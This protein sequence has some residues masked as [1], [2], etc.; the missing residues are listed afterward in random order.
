MIRQPAVSGLFYS[1]SPDT[2]AGDVARYLDPSAVP[3]PAVALISPHAGLMYSGHVAGAVYARV[4]LPPT[5]ILLG[6]NHTGVGPPI[7]VYREGTWLIPGWSVDVDHELADTILSRY[8]HARADTSA[9]HSE[10]CLEVQ[11]PFL[12]RANPHI[13]IVPIVLGHCPEE[14]YQELGFCLAGILDERRRENSAATP[15]LVS[16]TDMSHYEP[17]A[18]TRLKD[19][20]AIDAI[21]NLDPAGLGEAVRTYQIT[22]CGYAPTVTVLHAVRSLGATAAA[23]IRYATSG[24]VSGERT[25]VVGYAGLV[26]R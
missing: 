13:R 12:C 8:P 15:L 5:V 7:S 10:H 9:H 16:S 18:T 20:H 19:G 11:L 25:R 6:P 17:D 3:E 26:I 21:C 22:M 2:L 1:D 4:A 24:D 23:L 14:T